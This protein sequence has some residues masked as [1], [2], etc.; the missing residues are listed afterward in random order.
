MVDIKSILVILTEWHPKA[1]VLEQYLPHQPLKI[2]IDRDL[3]ERCQALDDRER[4]AALYLY[5]SRV[6][7]L[8]AMVAGAT[9]IDLD[10]NVCGEVTAHQAEHAAAKLA[11]ILA[12]RDAKRTA[13]ELTNN[14]KKTATPS[15]SAAA[16]DVSP[17]KEKPIMRL[18]TYRGEA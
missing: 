6:M 12:A 4:R 5:T 9:R 15:T 8:R 11:Q 10:G 7:Y 2:G 13:V 1:F 17:L 16:T 3:I 18:P 14:T